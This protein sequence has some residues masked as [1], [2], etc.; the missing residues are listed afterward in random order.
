MVHHS[1]TPAYHSAGMAAVVSVTVGIGGLYPLR[2]SLLPNLSGHFL[3]FRGESDNIM[4]SL[5]RKSQSAG[6]TSGEV[7]GGDSFVNGGFF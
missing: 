6:L 7:M 2:A 5:R 3:D 4:M 1:S